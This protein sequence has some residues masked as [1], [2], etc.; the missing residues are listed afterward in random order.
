MTAPDPALADDLRAALARAGIGGWCVGYANPR[1]GVRLDRPGDPDIDYND[2]TLHITVIAEGSAWWADQPVFSS[3]S[4]ITPEHERIV[5][6][7]RACMQGGYARTLAVRLGI[8]PDIERMLLECERRGWKAEVVLTRA[9]D[10]DLGD[11]DLCYGAV[12]TDRR[13]H[14]AWA[15]DP[16][17]ALA[18]ALLHAMGE[19]TP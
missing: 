12:E 18:R 19:E 7:V 4:W 5:G 14:A 17:E 15:P 13:H 2:V 10:A 8:V 9:V 6:L 11:E 3:D 16:A 1:Q